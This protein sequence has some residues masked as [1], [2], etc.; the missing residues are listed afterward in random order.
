[1]ALLPFPFFPSFFSPLPL[2]PSSPLFLFLFFF[3]FSPLF[4]SLFLFSLS[5]LFPFLFS[6]LPLP[7][8]F[9]SPSFSPSSS[10]PFFFFPLF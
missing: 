5:S 8:L 3:L 2:L 9:L 6:L 7:S 1:C 10:S 4:L